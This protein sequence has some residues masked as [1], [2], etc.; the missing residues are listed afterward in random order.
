[1]T[2]SNLKV[3]AG[4]AAGAGVGLL[5]GAGA[6]LVKGVKS[7]NKILAPYMPAINA[8]AVGSDTF[9][10][11]QARYVEDGIKALQEKGK[12]I[13][14]KLT[15]KLK[16]GFRRMAEHLPDVKKLARNTRIKWVAGLAAA[17]TAVG[18]GI[19][20]IVNKVKA[21]KSQKA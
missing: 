1:M 3:G 15:Y 9:V 5:A 6:G 21:D 14:P 13:T 20:A 10:K 4:L 17:G 18:L 12:E 19:A 7:S 11:E 16:D 2:N 8:G